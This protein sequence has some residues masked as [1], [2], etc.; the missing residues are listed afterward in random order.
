MKKSE[1][2]QIQHLHTLQLQNFMSD[3]GIPSRFYDTKLDEFGVLGQAFKNVIL[4]P[5]YFVDMNNLFLYGGVH[6]AAI[7]FSIIRAMRIIHSDDSAHCI[8]L[9]GLIAMQDYMAGRSSVT[10][11]RGLT[12]AFLETVYS[13]NK[14]LFIHDFVSNLGIDQPYTSRERYII[15]DYI[16]SRFDEG[17]VTIV[18]SPFPLDQLEGVWSKRFLMDMESQMTIQIVNQ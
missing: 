4:S 8:S 2:L 18:Y 9:A 16:R 7:G 11:Y 10:L 13:L 15:E 6:G 1:N 12:E 14:T 5:T 17:L 3:G